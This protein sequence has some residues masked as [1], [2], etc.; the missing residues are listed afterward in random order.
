MKRYFH[1]LFEGRINRKNF[2]LGIALL[3]FFDL[4]TLIILMVLDPILQV[5]RRS[6]IGN[7]A[8]TTG[9]ILFVVIFVTFL[10]SFNVRRLHDVGL[11]G[12]VYGYDLI[13]KGDKKENK[14]GKP[15]LPE[16]D[17]KGLFGF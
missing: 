10:F 7:F 4:F 12:M 6:V 11:E 1:R 13:R 8:V 5:F 17:F 9:Q 3:V 14:Y 2:V 16:I 15:P